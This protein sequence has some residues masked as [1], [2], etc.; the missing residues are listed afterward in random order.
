MA[1][2]LFLAWSSPVDDESDAAFNSWYEN[3]HIPQ[4]RTAIGSVTAVHRYRTADLPGGMQPAHR[5]LAVYEMDSDDIPAAAAAL[6][7]AS[8][9]GRLEMTPAMDLTAPPAIHW[10]EGV[11]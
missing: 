3:T 5:Y 10:Y 2:G 4:V 8:G 6:A 9:A 11:N 1:R 7:A